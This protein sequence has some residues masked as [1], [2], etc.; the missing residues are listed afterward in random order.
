MAEET[1]A[2]ITA[3]IDSEWEKKLQRRHARVMESLTAMNETMAEMIKQFQELGEVLS[4][5][6]VAQFDVDDI[7]DED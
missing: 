2:E 7:E 4:L 3:Q 1:M 6:D 5:F